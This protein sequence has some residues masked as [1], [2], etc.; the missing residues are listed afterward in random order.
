MKMG[1]FVLGG[2]AGAALAVMIRRNRRL[3]AMA[4]SL[5]GLLSERMTGMKDMA[6]GKALNNMKFAGGKL[7]ASDFGK[8]H[9]RDGAVG[10]SDGIE[11]VA[12]LASED[13]GVQRE[14]DEILEDNG[15][16][17]I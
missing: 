7:R 11:Q 2:L 14:I 17:R 5:G 12:R 4:G 9:E 8:K 15:R 1:P 10:H 6:F 13:P 16:H 3:S